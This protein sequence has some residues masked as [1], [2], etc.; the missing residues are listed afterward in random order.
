MEYHWWMNHWQRIR[1]KD[2]IYCIDTRY[3]NS[4]LIRELNF[5]GG[6][7]GGALRK[8]IDLYMITFRNDGRK[9]FK[10]EKKH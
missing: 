3:K 9:I 2:E 7:K 1:H 4:G 5:V 6:S 10:L 8:K